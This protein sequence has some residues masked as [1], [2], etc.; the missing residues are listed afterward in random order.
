VKSI[1]PSEWALFYKLYS[2]LLATGISPVE[3]LSRLMQEPL[4]EKLQTR[5]LPLFATLPS[6][7]S[8]ADCLKLKPFSL[9]AATL[10]L[11]EKTT[12]TEEHINLLQALSA[13]F[14]QANWINQLRGNTLYW[15]MLYF[16]VGGGTFLY[17]VYGLLPHFDSFFENSWGM[18]PEETSLLLALRH[19][20]VFLLF[21]LMAVFLALRFRPM[22]LRKFV[23]RIRLIPPWGILSE[24]ISLTRFTHMLSLLLSKNVSPK[25]ALILAAATTGNVII[26]RRLQSAFAE[27]S[28]LQPLNASSSAA[29]ILKTCPLVP[30][31]YTAAL[32]IAEKTQKVEETLPEL[33]QMSAD[34]LC[35]YTQTLNN[36]IDITSKILVFVIIFWVALAVYLPLFSIGTLV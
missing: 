31:T 26:E 8:L 34:S 28:T 1:K 14:S 24:K 16:I 19:W 11:F 29:D 22:L 5:L 18:L 32:S 27:A 13:R 9:D 2:N 36:C 15:P 21:L 10:G 4:S 17:I 25:Q 35:R 30:G 6:T 3:S 20:V 12:H 23:D 33:I 7:A